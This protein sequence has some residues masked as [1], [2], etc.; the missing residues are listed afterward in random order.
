MDLTLLNTSFETQA[1]LD[2]Y[3]SAIWTD[4]YYEAGDFELYL[5]ASKAAL[6]LFKR[7]DYICNPESEHLMIVE[8]IELSTDA[9][10]G[11]TIKVTGRS[12]ESI[13]DR[14][15]V[16]GQ[17]FYNGNLQDAIHTIL[18]NSIISPKDANRKIPGF[19]FK[20]STDP[21]ITGLTLTA[22]YFGDNVY[23]IIKSVCENHHVGWKVTLE[24][25]FKF[26]FEMYYGINR[27]YSQNENPYVV[28]SPNF[29]NL[30]NSNYVTSY[31]SM[32]NVV[33]IG[34]TGDGYSKKTAEYGAATGLYRR[35]LS[36]DQSSLS[37]TYT[38]EE[39]EQKE[40]TDDEYS[41]QMK[42][43]GKDDLENNTETNAFD[44]E[45]SPNFEYTYGDDYLLGDL[46]QIQNA[47]G[48]GMESR[49]IE[50]VY[51]DST[52]KKSVYPTFQADTKT[53]PDQYTSLNYSYP[54][55]TGMLLSFS[56]IDNPIMTWN[57]LC[58]E[59]EEFTINY[60][61]LLRYGNSDT[62]QYTYRIFEPGKYT[63]SNILFGK[64]PSVGSTKQ[65]WIGTISGNSAIAI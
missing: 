18:N 44:G 38:T 52:E 3:I 35:E 58:Q 49:I 2:H 19:I 21:H 46:V 47:Y 26:V 57:N 14:R 7:G 34:G 45:V 33:L 15:I 56:I 1:V 40:F 24:S 53:S 51:S 54:E 39:G 28:F 10:K 37:K 29:D 59:G 27:S 13:L 62:K 55:V 50:I 41:N 12:L 5:P 20:A 63:A 43:K 42:Q 11:D 25:D 16:W 4:R 17:E 48:S 61:S 9:E 8:S 30:I 23:S 6:N 65:A 22:Q 36:S 64:D 32:K 60:R 31:K